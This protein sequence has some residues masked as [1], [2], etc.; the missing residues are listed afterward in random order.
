MLWRKQNEN[1]TRSQSTNNPNSLPSAGKL[2]VGDKQR[3]LTTAGKC[4]MMVTHG[5]EAGKV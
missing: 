1:A 5:R 2:E 3:N 4:A